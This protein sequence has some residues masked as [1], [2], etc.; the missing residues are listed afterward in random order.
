MGSNAPEAPKQ[1]LC[2][3][4]GGRQFQRAADNLF[5][6]GFTRDA[7]GNV[8]TTRDKPG[9]SLAAQGSLPAYPILKEQSELV[10]DRANSV[11]L[12]P[13]DPVVLRHPASEPLDEVVS[14]V[15]PGNSEVIP[16]NPMI[17]A[18]LVDREGSVWVGSEAGLHRFSYSPLVRQQLPVASAPWFMLAPDD[19]GA[20]WIS[21]GDGVGTSTLFRV[22][23]GKVD[24]QRSTAGV[25]S[26]AYRAPDKTFWF[27]GEGGLWHMIGSRLTEV[28]L[29]KELA[30]KGRTLVTMT[31]DGSGGFWVSFTGLGLYRL[32]DG[33]WTKYQKTPA[34][35]PGVP[36]RRVRRR[37][38]CL[39]SP[40][41]RAAC[42][43]AASRGSW[44]CSTPIG[45][46]P[47]AR[48][49]VSR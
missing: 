37:P 30:G 36:R 26:F 19:G 46:K 1:L 32:K 27:G 7:D 4:R 21:A 6:L 44:R 40:V 9:S 14:K 34:Y 28:E 8:L 43:S 39:H 11:W 41:L 5:V 42:G 20:V 13:R 29:P 48:T 47:S 17:H 49:T 25:S 35:R 33:G 31:H 23:E 16:I 2:L 22:A 18:I 38:F 15:S 10:V 12:I 3:A 45:N 24:L